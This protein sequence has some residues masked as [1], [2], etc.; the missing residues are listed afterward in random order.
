MKIC[1]GGQNN[2]VSV[3]RPINPNV[4]N[5]VLFS[6]RFAAGFM[7]YEIEEMEFKIFSVNGEMTNLRADIVIYVE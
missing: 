5:E 2:T 4:A 7:P 3:E 1:L 6:G